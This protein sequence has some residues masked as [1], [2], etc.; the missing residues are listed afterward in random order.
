[1]NFSDDSYDSLNQSKSI[2]NKRRCSL[3][4]FQ[5][6]N[7]YC[8]N[9]ALANNS[10]VENDAANET[11]NES[12]CEFEY[13]DDDELIVCRICDEKVPIDMIEEHTNSC[14]KLYKKTS[15]VSSIDEQ[16]KQIMSNAYKEFMCVKWPGIESNAIYNL[17]PLLRLNLFVEETLQVNV[18]INDAP[19]E[20]NQI[21][22][23]IGKMLNNANKETAAKIQSIMKSLKPL[24]GQKIKASKAIS[25]AGAILKQ[26]RKAARKIRIRNRIRKRRK[27]HQ[28]LLKQ[29]QLQQQN[30]ASSKRNNQN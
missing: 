11:N 23:K 9:I 5:K 18:N 3:L 4:P 15:L 16:I 29:L 27:N 30:A 24:I 10:D 2:Q 20:L 26:T 6:S 17:I 19:Q 14:L 25:S 7:S 22:K 13:D 8:S 1:M 28:N 12:T 21:K